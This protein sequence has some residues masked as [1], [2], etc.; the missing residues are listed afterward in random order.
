MKTRA[1]GAARCAPARVAGALGPSAGA[2]GRAGTA[3][4][5]ERWGA[6]AVSAGR[7]LAA[8]GAGRARTPG[9]RDGESRARRASCSPAP[10]DARF[11]CPGR[12]LVSRGCCPTPDPVPV[13]PQAKVRVSCGVANAIAVVRR[14]RLMARAEGRSDAMGSPAHLVPRCGH[15]AAPGQLRCW[16]LPRGLAPA[17]LWVIS[18]VADPSRVKGGEN[19]LSGKGEEKSE[20]SSGVGH[21]G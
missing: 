10:R 7:P 3:V 12:R 2:R 17:V 9:T 19:F 16:A 4:R 21:S 1:G 18:V 20:S 5:A 14:G 11:K 13:L 6:A 8:W 15:L